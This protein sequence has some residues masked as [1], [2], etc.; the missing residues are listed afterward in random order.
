MALT[1]WVR[2]LKWHDAD[3]VRHLCAMPLE[4]VQGDGVDVRRDLAQ[5][6][7]A[8]APGLGQTTWCEY[9]RLRRARGRRAL[10][11]G[12]NPGGGSPVHAVRRW[13]RA[14]RPSEPNRRIADHSWTIGASMRA[15]L[16]NHGSS[17]YVDSP[18]SRS[19]HMVSISSAMCPIAAS[20]PRT[21]CEESRGCF[22]TD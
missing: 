20:G 7:L 19:N 6:G 12:P 4:L 9:R 2:L 17:P 5:A 15:V 1:A 22:V 16:T 14:G 13:R 3:G 21:R 8:I 18:E 10:A 11:L